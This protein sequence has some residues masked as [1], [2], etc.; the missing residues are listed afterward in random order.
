MNMNK[1]Q[2]IWLSLSIVMLARC[3]E[4]REDRDY[5]YRPVPFT[6]VT[7]NDSF[8][9]PRLE[10]N[11]KVTIPYAFQQCEKT[12][13]LDNFRIAGGIKEG[14][15]CSEYPFDDSDVY[16]IIEG[17]SYTLHLEYDPELDRFLDELIAEIAA[18][19]EDDGYLYTAR[20]MK[21]KKPVRW[22]D[23]DRWSNLYLG[24]ELY[25]AGHFYEAAVAHHLAT[26]K[27]TM[28]DM[29]IK[30][31]NLVA[32]VFG[33]GK[34]QAVP[35]H[36][37][38]EIGLVK[39]YRVTGNRKYL[40]LAQFFLD[41]R[42]RANGRELFGEYSQDHEPVTEQT[43]AVGHSVR[44]VYMFSGMADI[45]AITGNDAYVEAI[46]GLWDDVVSGKIYLTGGIGA[47]GEWEGFGKSYELPNATAYA[48]T[49]ASIGNIFWN[50]RMF[51]LAGDG[52]YYDVLERV[53]Y[54]GLI[55][56]SGLSGDS[57]FYPNPLE[58]YGQHQR[59]P[60]FPCACCPSN[61]SRFMPSL[62]G[63]LYASRDDAIYVNL[64]VNGEADI[65]LGGQTVHLQQ[66]TDY[67][68][69]GVIKLSVDP[70]TSDTFAIHV[71]I[72]GWTRNEPIPG[73]LYEY[74]EPSE[75][76][77]TLAVNGETLPLDIEKG[78][79]RIERSWK[80]G[81]QIE[82]VLPM[83]I[84]R[85]VSHP[86]VQANRGKLALERGPLVYAIEWPDHNGHVSNLVLPADAK[87]EVDRREELFDGVTVIKGKAVALHE[88]EPHRREIELTAIP[89]YAWAYRGNGEMA[90][91][92][93]RNE[94][95]VRP[96]PK[97]TLASQSK[98]SASGGKTLIGLNDQWDPAS[99]E[100]RSRPYLHYW[101]NKGTVEWVQYDFPKMSK[102]SRV[103]VYWYDDTGRGDV[104]VPMSWKVLY[105]QG[106]DWI[107]VNPKGA[108][109]V[110]KDD[111][112]WAAF[113]T[114]ETTGLRL[115][116][117]SQREF[118]V[119]VLEWKVE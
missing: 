96:I 51:L 80:K 78:F 117:Q 41:Q 34:R 97:P 75:E 69:E 66:Q 40:D 48:E 4:P 44:A 50:H 6:S 18:A 94:D 15:F 7:I 23:E 109:G 102:V 81:D 67:P 42:G 21:S 114:V 108:F 3:S 37:E 5:P 22:V 12:G 82:L 112:N 26:G 39:L 111:Y 17:A 31:A 86:D 27:R 49:C 76:K 90:V 8:W 60:W 99:S 33:P 43:E 71:R 101:P 103:G 28:L 56:G 59:D 73:D 10:T 32:E 20:T 95:A 100:D 85:V 92:I 46:R 116:I 68:W 53:L 47:T 36:Q 106:D 11:R 93:S 25:N 19:Q 87:L 65:E 55:S 24:H 52:K 54:N 119:G 77:V 2:W 107:P 74:L 1:K 57:F 30:N 70:E 104:R 38:I 9:Q 29:A 83:P 115:E 88:V 118:S 62:P 35:G 110:T 98:V 45:A 13:R 89:Y 14:D 63:Y 61:L 91:W 64:F 16:K 105:R 72:P 79:V 58:S 84:R 113:E